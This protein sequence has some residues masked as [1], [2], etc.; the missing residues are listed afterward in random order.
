[1][2]LEFY[3]ETQEPEV[4]VF[5]LKQSDSVLNMYLPCSFY[6]LFVVSL[7]SG[8]WLAGSD[9]VVS[10]ISGVWLS[11]ADSSHRKVPWWLCCALH[12]SRAVWCGRAVCRPHPSLVVSITACSPRLCTTSCFKLIVYGFLWGS[13]YKTEVFLHSAS[14]QRNGGSSRVKARFIF[15]SLL[16]QEAQ[17][18]RKSFLLDGKEGN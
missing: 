12:L 3:W 15:C 11:V 18:W 1:M 9:G 2:W 10:L 16:H 7:I 17:P 13:G 6:G 14:V 5:P 4:Q 8:F